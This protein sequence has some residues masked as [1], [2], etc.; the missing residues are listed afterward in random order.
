VALTGIVPDDE[1]ESVTVTAAAAGHTGAWSVTA[2]AIC[3]TSVEPW[4]ISGSGPGTATAT[5]PPS[6][7]LFG[8]GFRV[9]AAPS[10]GR[11]RA[12]AL[13]PDLT[14]VRVTAGGPAADT[15]T[16]TAIA[17][18]RPPAAEM[19]RNRV[20]TSVTAWPSTVEAQDTEPDLSAY[21][22]GA[23]VTG[24]GAATL[25]AIVPGPDGGRTW[26]RG[27]LVGAPSRPAAEFGGGTGDGDGS[28]T[29]EA[30]L[31]GTFH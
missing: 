3:E 22:T 20:G 18:C 9:A 15:T 27:T 11:V 2:F 31:I 10:A 21:A 8:L 24:P 5:C 4:R 29:A 1:G 7:R 16:V 25:D 28:L 17:L 23:T 14:A 19:R 26:A 13:D 12:V 6:T 30:A